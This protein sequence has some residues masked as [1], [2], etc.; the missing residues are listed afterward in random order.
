LLRNKLLELGS[1]DL[2]SE[3]H[4]SNV[5]NDF[6]FYFVGESLFFKGKPF[7]SGQNALYGKYLTFLVK[8]Y[9]KD[10]RVLYNDFIAKFNATN[11]QKTTRKKIYN[12]LVNPSLGLHRRLRKKNYLDISKIA[13]KIICIDESDTSVFIFNNKI[14]SQ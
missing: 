12:A 9:L 13:E 10:N 5:A 1:T 4:I 11:P 8:N 7:V 6:Y 14:N 2:L 3:N